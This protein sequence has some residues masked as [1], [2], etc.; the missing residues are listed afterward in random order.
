MVSA[1]DQNIPVVAV[2][3]RPTKITLRRT[4]IFV[5]PNATVEIALPPD[6]EQKFSP[7]L[8]RASLDSVPGENPAASGD[9]VA[10]PMKRS[11]RLSGASGTL[12]DD[13]AAGSYLPSTTNGR[14]A[15]FRKVRRPR[16]PDVPSSGDERD[17]S[18]PPPPTVADVVA[19]DDPVALPF[20]LDPALALDPTLYAVDSPSAYYPRV[21]QPLL[22]IEA[23]KQWLPSVEDDLTKSA[24]AVAP[25]AGKERRATRSERRRGAL[26]WGVEV[27]AA[28]RWKSDFDLD[29]A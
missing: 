23:L 13:N 11:R 16:E 26:P 10:S 5:D 27:P 19:I 28:V 3:A 6:H 24:E 14:P 22:V 1:P 20:A 15:R 25:S 29:G 8:K 17:S 2:P 4:P 18:P 21:A 9:V 7:H 12:P